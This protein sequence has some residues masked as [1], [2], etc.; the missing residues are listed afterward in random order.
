M[1]TL[2]LAGGL[3]LC[4]FGILQDQDSK[5]KT[6]LDDVSKKTK[7]FSSIHVDFNLKLE[8][9]KS[10]INE[11]NN[12][13]AI[14]KGSKYIV[15]FGKHKLL[16]DGKY[17]WSIDTDGKQVTET[18]VE[19][20]DDEMNPTKMMTIWEKGFKY[21]YVAEVKEDGTTLHE[22][23]LFPTNPAKTKFHTVILKIDKAKSQIHSVVIK[24]K[25]GD[26]HTLKITKFTTNGAADDA[27]FKYDTKK[28]P[29]YEKID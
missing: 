11:S 8:N 14:M 22:I 27:D 24:K 20:A 6:I 23:H 28:Y 19:E 15:D 29:G 13:K 9:T 12:G 18:P 2:L 1:K 4:S 3:A 16:C 7:A 10:K 5:A 17:V 21:R 25:N 26:V